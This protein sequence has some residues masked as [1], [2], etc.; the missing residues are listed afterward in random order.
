MESEPLP[1]RLLSL[2][3][4]KHIFFI[5]CFV[6]ANCSAGGSFRLDRELL[7]FL[8]QKPALKALLLDTFEF[9]WT[10]AASRIGVKVNSRLGGTRIG[11]YY[12]KAKHKG[13][14][15]DY[16]FT[17]IFHTEIKFIDKKG[18]ETRLPDAYTVEEVFHSFEVIPTNSHSAIWLEKKL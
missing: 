12:L 6:S 3:E 14:Q 18:R 16:T 5:Y 11:P 13:A 1:S 2:H 4:A 17:V 9:H 15:G 8:D 10:G 7:P